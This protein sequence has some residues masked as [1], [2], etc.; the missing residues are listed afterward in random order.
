MI[1][2]RMR[3]G[4]YKLALALYYY[5]YSTSSEQLL[6]YVRNLNF[7]KEWLNVLMILK[8]EQ[9]SDLNVAAKDL[10]SLFLSHCHHSEKMPGK[11]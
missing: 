4:L 8:R 5:Y 10:L 11:F 9:R 2:S 3:Q 6:T 1:D 7:L